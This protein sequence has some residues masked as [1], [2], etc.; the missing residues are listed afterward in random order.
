[1]IFFVINIIIF[2]KKNIVMKRKFNDLEN[3]E[4]S[5]FFKAIEINDIETVKEMLSE[6]PG[7]RDQKNDL[8]N[9]ALSYAITKKRQ[10]IA[11]H[12]IGLGADVNLVNSRG[13]SILHQ[14]L[15]SRANSIV[16]AILERDDLVITERYQINSFLL[17][18]SPELLA[19]TLY[20]MILKSGKSLGSL[21]CKESFNKVIS[22]EIFIKIIFNLICDGDI[23]LEQQTALLLTIEEL[24][25]RLENLT[26][27][28]EETREGSYCATANTVEGS[29]AE[30]VSA[31]Q[32]AVKSYAVVR[33]P[34]VAA[35]RDE[36][37]KL[38]EVPR[39][40]NSFFAALARSIYKDVAPDCVN[41][42]AASY[43]E[44]ATRY[45]RE[46]AKNFI[47]FFD[48]DRED[49]YWYIDVL[50][51]SG[52][53][54][55][56]QIIQAFADESGITIVVHHG[57]EIYTTVP[58]GVNNHNGVNHIFYDGRHYEGLVE[59]S[60]DR[61]VA[62]ESIS[63]EEGVAATTDS[64]N[65]NSNEALDGFGFVFDSDQVVEADIVDKVFG[66]YENLFSGRWFLSTIE[67]LQDSG[68]GSSSSDEPI[69]DYYIMTGLA[70]LY[71]FMP[72][73][74][75]GHI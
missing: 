8:N 35:V 5:I 26:H 53:Q 7:L 59:A 51:M 10:T 25:I 2:I 30:I 46:N 28:S 24:G 70:T 9:G 1:M 47:E 44:R 56:N 17:L 62:K 61:D 54:V 31:F 13:S 74:F 11:A 34:L 55:S 65:L 14:A 29:D 49:L 22:S 4:V 12:L 32:K 18:K 36:G 23:N 19:K 75:I 73:K 27:K 60:D 50:E 69:D 37:Y 63:E 3:E 33:S 71:F 52:E 58:R 43:R 48:D 68:L 64:S 20:K 57:R 67:Q 41:E 16:V 45:M 72:D 38:L 66:P 40:G 6:S 42:I 39:D 21:L 15:S